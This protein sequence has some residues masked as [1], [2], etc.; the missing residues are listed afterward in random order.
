MAPLPPSPPAA[1]VAL[2]LSP[3]LISPVRGQSSCGFCPVGGSPPL[4]PSALLDP[5]NDNS[6]TCGDVHNTLLSSF[7]PGEECTT[8]QTE[9]LLELEFGYPSQCGYCAVPTD[10]VATT[11]VLCPT[12]SVPSFPPDTPL[13]LSDGTP[14]TCGEVNY[15]SQFER[16]FSDK[17]LE[18]Q[19]MA[20]YCGCEP[21]SC[22]ICP[23]GTAM[24]DPSKWSF[25]AE[26]PCGDVVKNSAQLDPTG[27]DCRTMQTI[28]MGE[29]GCQYVPPFEP[30]CT[31]CSDGS[32]V[33]DPSFQ[34][35]PGDE[36]STCGLY[37][38]YATLPPFDAGG[39]QCT[40]MQSTFGAAC[41]CDDAPEPSCQVSCD[42]PG[43]I[44]NA[45]H[46]VADFEVGNAL[47]LFEGYHICAEILFDMSIK[48]DEICRAKAVRELQN[49]C[50]M[51]PYVPPPP[52]ET[53]GAAH[54]F[55][56]A[57]AIAAIALGSAVNIFI[58]W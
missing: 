47:Y 36:L 33:P 25:A 34:L 19:A 10:E 54:L 32:V 11:C 30:G 52:G 6:T 3:S 15:L 21:T 12:G 23:D 43:T 45:T 44:F 17:C 53:S 18:L 38:W 46:V 29:C 48:K 31:L 5:P 28:V 1:L 55:T 27:E 22:E 16:I 50:C 20:P 4:N 35:F 58:A 49:E 14:S 7:P 37:S 26:M 41:G 56:S 57:S 2:L 51:E 24:S 13:T 9:A 42:E 40:A 39:E 8:A